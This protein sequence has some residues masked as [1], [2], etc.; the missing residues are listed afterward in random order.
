MG[1]ETAYARPLSQR[2]LLAV[3]PHLR[4]SHCRYP[5]LVN[6]QLPPDVRRHL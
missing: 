3:E 6:R 1:Q 5:E 4:K 2:L